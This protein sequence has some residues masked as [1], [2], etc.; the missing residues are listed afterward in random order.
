MLFLLSQQKI[1]AIKNNPLKKLLVSSYDLF[2]LGSIIN[3]YRYG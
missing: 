1:K 2:S 3:S